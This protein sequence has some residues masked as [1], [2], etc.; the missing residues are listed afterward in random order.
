M[1]NMNQH[2]W[3]ITPYPCCRENTAIATLSSATLK[4]KRTLFK[5]Q[6][7]VFYPCCRGNHTVTQHTTMVLSSEFS[8]AGKAR[9]LGE[10]TLVQ[11][12]NPSHSVELCTVILEAVHPLILVLSQ[13]VNFSPPP[14]QFRIGRIPKLPV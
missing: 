7:R 10:S 6:F 13:L 3:I 2:F 4:Q 1:K 12:T 9:S 11:Q 8:L 5:S 14:N